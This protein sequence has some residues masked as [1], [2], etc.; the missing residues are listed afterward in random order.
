MGARDDIIEGTWMWSADDS[1]LDYID[2]YK[3]E[4]NNL[5]GN[6]DC[7]ELSAGHNWMWNDVSCKVDDRQFICEKRQVYLY[8]RIC[9]LQN[10]KYKEN[11][12]Y[13]NNAYM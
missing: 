12:I 8:L 11:D 2:W 9:Q 13:K 5:G 3:T 4:P 10:G 7:L 6:E 1:V